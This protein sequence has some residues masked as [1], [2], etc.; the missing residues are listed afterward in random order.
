MVELNKSFPAHLLSYKIVYLETN[1]NGNT[2]C[3]LF[4]LIN[5]NAHT[6]LNTLFE[7]SEK[8]KLLLKYYTP[9]CTLFSAL[10]CDNG[11]L[12]STAVFPIVKVAFPHLLAT[13]VGLSFGEYGCV[14]W[15]HFILIKKHLVVRTS[16]RKQRK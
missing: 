13:W 12:L 15:A 8:D 9:R 2:T 6:M 3:P 10:L 14:H 7:S 5:T 1:T 16:F 11:H 4:V